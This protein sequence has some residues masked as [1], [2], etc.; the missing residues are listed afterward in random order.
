M[1]CARRDQRRIFILFEVIF[2]HG[3]NFVV[4]P[5]IGQCASQFLMGGC[6]R[7]IEL[8]CLSQQLHGRIEVSRERFQTAQVLVYGR[9]VRSI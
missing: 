6:D 3:V 1:F 4:S 5:G 7:W 8:D 2:H 9:V